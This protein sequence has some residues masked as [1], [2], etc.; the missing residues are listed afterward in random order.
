MKRTITISVILLIILIVSISSIFSIKKNMDYMFKDL[1][2]IE[3]NVLNKDFNT[4]TD[5]I[6]KL[7]KYWKDKSAIYSIFVKH[8]NIDKTTEHFKLLNQ[9]IKINDYENSLLQIENVKFYVMEI[10]TSELPILG[11]I[12]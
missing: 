6:K 10:Y 8:S 1:N 3:Q 7:N 12:L 2:R 9:A 5:N 4:A 11:N